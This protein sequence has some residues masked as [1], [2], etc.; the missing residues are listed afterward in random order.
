NRYAQ[1]RQRGLR[2]THTRQVGSTAGTG[3]D[4]FNTTG[5][6]GFGVVKQ[7]IR[8]T[9][10]RHHFYFISHAQ[11]VEHIGSVLHG[12]PVALRAHDD[13]NRYGHSAS[14][15][16]FGWW[17]CRQRESGGF[18]HKGG[19]ET[20]LAGYSAFSLAGCQ[21]CRADTAAAVAAGLACCTPALSGWF[22]RHCVSAF[23]GLRPLDR[24]PLHGSLCGAPPL[25]PSA[26]GGIPLPTPLA[27]V[28]DSSSF[29]K[30]N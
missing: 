30:P 14:S 13:S 29:T 8:G 9:V 22:S 11:L 10:G 1:H 18:Y 4:D 15:C 24:L 16:G 21:P 7:Q 5:L 19:G 3:D 12:G 2:G 6:R 26:R 17:Q 23:C 20:A 25:R 27:R 28:P